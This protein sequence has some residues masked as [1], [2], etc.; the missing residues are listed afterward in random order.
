MEWVARLAVP[1]RIMGKV[2][3]EVVTMQF[4]KAKTKI[5]NLLIASFI[6]EIVRQPIEYLP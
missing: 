2:H 1:G 3:R 4:I 6:D 5:P